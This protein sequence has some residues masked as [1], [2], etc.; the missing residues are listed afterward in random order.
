MY[1]PMLYRELAAA[2]SSELVSAACRA[3]SRLDWERGAGGTVR[4]RAGRLL[5]DV[6]HRLAADV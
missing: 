2:H 6:G 4:R 5:I 3:R 1:A